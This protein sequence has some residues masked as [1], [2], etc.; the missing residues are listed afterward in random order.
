MT[1]TL[2]TWLI[3]TATGDL[4]RPLAELALARGGRVV[5]TGTSPADLLDLADLLDGTD[6]VRLVA[7]EPG[8]AA[9]TA[10]AVEGGLDV[11]VTASAPGP[12]GDL[13]ARLA[14]DLDAAVLLQAALPALGERG[15]VA[16]HVTPAAGSWLEALHRSRQA[17]QGRLQELDV[18]AGVSRSAD[19]ADAPVRVLDRGLAGVL[20]LAAPAA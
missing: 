7:R 8:S 4:A 11:L 14:A 10:A 9:A 20:H 16:L 1:T 5:L 17:L 12:D 2:T 13:P 19:G 18:W 15:G 6:R 3:D